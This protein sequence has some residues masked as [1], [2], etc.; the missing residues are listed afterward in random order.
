MH[1][2]IDLLSGKAQT[3]KFNQKQFRFMNGQQ[4]TKNI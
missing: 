3:E 4:E 1:S 2:N